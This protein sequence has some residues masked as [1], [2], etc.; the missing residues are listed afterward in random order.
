MKNLLLIMFMLFSINALSQEK[1]TY[2][3]DCDNN[4]IYTKTSKTGLLLEKGT[5]N[6]NGKHIGVWKQ[7]DQNGNLIVIGR[8]KNGIKH[9]V[10]KHYHDNE[11]VEVVYS[12]G[13]KSKAKIITDIDFLV[14]TKD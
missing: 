12:N 13:L 7:Y 14:A 9:G 8:F 6:E 10:W 3:R 5:Y 1:E 4:I 11:Y 2:V